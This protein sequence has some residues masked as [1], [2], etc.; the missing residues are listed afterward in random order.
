MCA[1]GKSRKN[2]NTKNTNFKV[3][4]W[5]PARLHRNIASD[6]ENIANQY[7]SWQKDPNCDQIVTIKRWIV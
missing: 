6:L 3:V 5:N 2:K 7:G 4:L 1:M